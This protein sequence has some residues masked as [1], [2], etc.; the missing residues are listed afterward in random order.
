MN[1]P[2]KVI[3]YLLSLVRAALE[4]HGGGKFGLG[5]QQG[6]YLYSSLCVPLSPARAPRMSEALKRSC[7]I[8]LN[9]EQHG[10]RVS[11]S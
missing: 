2:E 4:Y 1:G 6:T 3:E 9:W 10:A 11:Q 7:R 5:S 8:T